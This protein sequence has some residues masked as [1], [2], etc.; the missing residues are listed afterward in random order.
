[1]PRQRARSPTPSTS[2]KPA[3]N[4][5]ACCSASHLPRWPPS[6]LGSGAICVAFMPPR[7]VG[8]GGGADRVKA[9]SLPQPPPPH[10]HH[11][12]LYEWGADLPGG[13]RLM[14]S[15]ATSQGRVI[16]MAAI[17]IGAVGAGV[18]VLRSDALLDRG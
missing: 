11:L 14:L 16:V 18:G 3:P 13:T 4:T 2:P 7:D 17:A 8:P 15:N 9:G 6:I 1:M 12:R 10:F 5:R